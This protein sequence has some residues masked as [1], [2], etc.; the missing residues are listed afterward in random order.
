MTSTENI[1]EN[2][3]HFLIP[4][5]LYDESRRI[6]S[7]KHRQDRNWMIGLFKSNNVALLINETYT[8]CLF[9]VLNFL[10][11]WCIPTEEPLLYRILIYLQYLS[12]L[13]IKFIWLILLSVDHM[14]AA[15]QNDIRSFFML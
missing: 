4:W 3:G 11:K 15:K 2:L 9:H 7:T 14:H 1:I 5:S 8:K 13:I 10:I 12:V 6:F